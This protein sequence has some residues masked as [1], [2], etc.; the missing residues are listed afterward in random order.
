MIVVSN[1][2][3]MAIDT[4]K[5][6]KIQSAKLPETD[7]DLDQNSFDFKENAL[8]TEDKS[9]ANR[10]LGNTITIENRQ[11][12]TQKVVTSYAGSLKVSKKSFDKKALEK[13]LKEEAKLREEMEK[14]KAPN[15]KPYLIDYEREIYIK[16]LGDICDQIDADEKSAE[17]GTDEKGSE[18]NK[19]TSKKSSANSGINQCILQ[20]KKNFLQ[21]LLGCEATIDPK[22]IIEEAN[23]SPTVNPVDKFSLGMKSQME[24]LAH[25]QTNIRKQSIV[26]DSA[27]N[28]E[29]ESKS[30]YGLTEESVNISE[31]SEAELRIYNQRKANLDKMEQIEERQQ[32]RKE[33]LDREI[34]NAKGVQYQR[35]RHIML[36]TILNPELSVGQIVDRVKALK[37]VGDNEVFLGMLGGKCYIKKSK[38]F[39]NAIAYL[40]R[41]PLE[42][43]RDYET[44]ALPSEFH[45]QLKDA[46]GAD[47]LVDPVSK[48]ATFSLRKIWKLEIIAQVANKM[49]KMTNLHLGFSGQF[50]DF[51]YFTTAADIA[52][53]PDDN[54]CRITAAGNSLIED[55]PDLVSES[56]RSAHTFTYEKIEADPN[57]IQSLRLP[58]CSISDLIQSKASFL[59]FV[60]RFLQL[61][62]FSKA[63]SS[64]KEL[65]EA[66]EQMWKTSESMRFFLDKIV[67]LSGQ[68][69]GRTFHDLG[70]EYFDER[71]Y[72]LSPDSIG[73]MYKN[74]D[75]TNLW[76]EEW[77][78]IFTF[79]QKLINEG[80]AVL[81]R[82]WLSDKF[83]KTAMN[84][85]MNHQDYEDFLKIYYTYLSQWE[86][87]PMTAIEATHS[88]R[89]VE[90]M[91]FAR[92]REAKVKLVMHKGA[93]SFFNGL[94]HKGSILSQSK[95]IFV[96]P[97]NEDEPP[98]FC[99]DH[100]DSFI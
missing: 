52:F 11:K 75:L 9:P 36:S 66:E 35:Y 86:K 43:Y 50:S 44:L 39:G 72:G 54:F 87:K 17:D 1:S 6:N 21:S 16:E 5:A 47:S 59:S 98:N 41:I 68:S 46:F 26:F 100:D 70:T 31:M 27:F 65:I 53:I 78:K 8:A 88:Q 92:S 7:S 61:S 37:A 2:F 57:K 91:A 18:D 94:K 58:D 93:E 34:A 4:P 81:G 40:Q 90:L 3:S 56:I 49:M 15:T 95:P 51:L 99:P 63:D 71:L 73:T 64:I 38:K 25:E 83:K 23:V 85:I 22:K 69:D 55:K 45:K 20:H 14:P 80:G 24:N 13:K 62:H 77:S 19:E 30:D 12:R 82:F 76:S 96:T 28:K 29:A 97:H 33:K 10:K 42:S 60:V 67:S 89:Q 74:Y 48:L 79:A 84:G 32:K